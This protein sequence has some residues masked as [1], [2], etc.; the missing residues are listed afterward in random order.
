MRCWAIRL[1]AVRTRRVW[2]LRTLGKGCARLRIVD[3]APCYSVGVD[4]RAALWRVHG[5]F[6]RDAAAVMAEAAQPMQPLARYAAAAGIL[7]LAVD[8]TGEIDLAAE[9]AAVE[10]ALAGLVQRGQASWSGL[11]AAPGATSSA[12]AAAAMA[13]GTVFHFV[14]HGFFGS[15]NGRG[16]VLLAG[17]KEPR[18]ARRQ[19]AGR[20]LAAHAAAAPGG[21]QCLSQRGDDGERSLC[22][23][24]G[25][26]VAARRAGGDC[27][28]VCVAAGAAR[29]W[30]RTF[31]EALADGMA[32]RVR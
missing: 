3:L 5:T 6:A 14:G 30:S 9:Q 25:T 27:H 28:A 11:P 29:E 15:D 13:P 7:G 16:A 21:A 8:P 31:Y 32:L 12:R 10:N 23:C 4:L 24:G 20:L 26:L 18:V 1:S 19:P 17:R 22:R 2:A